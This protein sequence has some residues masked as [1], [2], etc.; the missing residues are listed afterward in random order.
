MLN[1]V[2]MH[3]IANDL[4][5]INGIQMNGRRHLEFITIANFDNMANFM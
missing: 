4:W 3:A 5:A 2:R 1:F